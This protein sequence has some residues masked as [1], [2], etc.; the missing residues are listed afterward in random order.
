MKDKRIEGAGHPPVY[1]PA[2]PF[3]VDQFSFWPRYDE[4]LDL[5]P[6]EAP[7]DPAFTEELGYNP[8]RGRTALYITD[9]AEEKAPSSI[10]TGFERWEMIACIDQTRRGLPLRQW[11]IFA[12]YNYL[13]PGVR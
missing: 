13:D 5:K 9:R 6:G 11:R 10:K 1:I 8:F 4:L 12:C 2:E 7:P 3:F